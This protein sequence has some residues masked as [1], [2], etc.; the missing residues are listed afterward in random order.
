[1]QHK[2]KR[3]NTI[4][5]LRDEKGKLCEDESEL[6]KITTDKMNTFLLIE[7]TIEEILT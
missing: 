7:F 3:R 2:E 6:E 4:K 1:M 5:E